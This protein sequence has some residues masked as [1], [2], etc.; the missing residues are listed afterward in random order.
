MH[1]DSLRTFCHVV[2]TGSFSVAAEKHGVTPSAISQIIA[3]LEKQWN[4]QLF[5]RGRH[6]LGEVTPA[7]RAAYDV[8]SE[9]LRQAGE[10]HRALRRL[11]ETADTEIRLAACHSIGLHQLPIFLD[12]FNEESKI[13]FLPA[14]DG[15]T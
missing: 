1:V 2:E 5:T 15:E 10:L 4:V 14:P 9:V 13:N 3:H 6:G 12:G 11:R 7:G 8:A